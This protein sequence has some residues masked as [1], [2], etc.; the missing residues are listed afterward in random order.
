MYES[1]ADTIVAPATPMSLRAPLAIIRLSGPAV[2]SILDTHLRLRGDHQLKPWTLVYADWVD[3]AGIVDDV[4]CVTY[5]AERSYTG[6]SMAEIFCHGNPLFVE[7]ILTN[8]QVAGARLAKPGEFSLRALLNGKMDLVQVEAV[9]E[10]VQAKTRYHA[11]LVRRQARGPLAQFAKQSV[12]EILQIQAHLEASID[13][14]EEDVDAMAQHL[15]LERLARVAES[16]RQVLLSAPFVRGMKRGFRVLLT[17]APNAGKST[18]FNRI[19]GNERAIVSEI[20]GTTRDFINEEIELKGLPV[21]LIDTAGVRE[22]DD[23]IEQL[24]IGKILQ[25]LEDVDLILYL[26]DASQPREPYVELQAMP[27][28]KWLTVW[29][30]TDLEPNVATVGIGVHPHDEA[31]YQ[32]LIDEIVLRLSA[33]MQGQAV[34]VTNQRQADLLTAAEAL[35]LQAKDDFAAGFGEEIVSTALNHVRTLL[36]EITGETTVEDVLDRMFSNFCLGK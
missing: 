10:L 22:T 13:Y 3:A 15:L 17:G 19:L 1:D 27:S 26:N 30:K 23:P 29:T 2:T 36:G 5:P 7:T 4:T 20:A 25:L 31:G 16:L 33:P 14:G 24:G 12:E 11:D 35:V 32:H 6:Q 28:E 9:H 8:C 18:L 21:V 34:W